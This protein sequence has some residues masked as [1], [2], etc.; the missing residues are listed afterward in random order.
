MVAPTRAW[1]A[2]IDSLPHVELV[3]EPELSI[4]LF[5]RPG[6]DADDYDRWSQRLL[7]EQ[8][9]FVTPTRWHGEPVAR[10]ALLHPGTTIEIIDE[11][12]VTTV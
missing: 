3:R 2:R 12:L 6:W 4:V 10:L 5:R 1:A 8:I 9:A 11:I 7:D